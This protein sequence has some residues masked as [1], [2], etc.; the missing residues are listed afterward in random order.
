[1]NFRPPKNGVEVTMKIT[2]ISSVISVCKLC[3]LG[4]LISS[5]SCI[6]SPYKPS[7]MFIVLTFYINIHLFMFLSIHILSNRNLRY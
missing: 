6:I 2:E 3:Q 1:M 4:A 5:R 7:K